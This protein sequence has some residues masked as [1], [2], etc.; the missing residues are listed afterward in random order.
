[1]ETDCPYLAPQARRG[2]RNEPAFL[3]FT[4]QAIAEARGE[5]VEAI[6]ATTGWNT[7]QL[8]ALPYGN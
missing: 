4:A 2:K 1:L 7:V 5:A 3:P 8:F 6:V